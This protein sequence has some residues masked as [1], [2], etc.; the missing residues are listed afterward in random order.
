VVILVWVGQVMTISPEHRKRLEELGDAQVR[1]ILASGTFDP[2]FGESAR[3]WLVRREE[4]QRAHIEAETQRSESTV[5]AAWI[6]A[7]GAIGAIVVG[8]IGICVAIILW[9]FPRH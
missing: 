2:P 6:A 3:E 1:F 5:K 8:I 7:Y 4:A 9:R